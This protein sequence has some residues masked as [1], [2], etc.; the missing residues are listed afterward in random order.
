MRRKRFCEPGVFQQGVPENEWDEPGAVQ[1][2]LRK[3]M[4]CTS[5]CVDGFNR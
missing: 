3:V 1:E 5:F 2:D 4:S